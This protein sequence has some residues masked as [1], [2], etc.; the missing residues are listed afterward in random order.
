MKTAPILFSK[1]KYKETSR[2]VINVKIQKFGMKSHSAYSIML[3]VKLPLTK[4]FR[5]NI[6]INDVKHS[7]K[8][9]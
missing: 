8:A 5:N 6:K 7:P 3:L 2:K 4:R 9:I 1:K